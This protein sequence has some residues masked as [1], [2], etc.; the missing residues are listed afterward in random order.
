MEGT[1]S[2]E[3]RVVKGSRGSL[4]PAKKT[5]SLKSRS[6]REMFVV[7]SL[8]VDLGATINLDPSPRTELVRGGAMAP[9]VRSWNARFVGWFGGLVLWEWSRLCM[10]LRNGLNEVFSFKPYLSSVDWV[11]AFLV[12]VVWQELLF[13]S[14][15]ICWQ[16]LRWG[17]LAS[18]WVYRCLDARFGLWRVLI[19]D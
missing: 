7:M 11:S 15:S 17:C 3:V 1:Y 13:F 5:R 10:A 16:S 12:C 9:G 18:R 14:C 6:R 4:G 2:F 8:V 19:V